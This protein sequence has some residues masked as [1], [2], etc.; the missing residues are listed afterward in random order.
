MKYEENDKHIFSLFWADLDKQKLQVNASLIIDDPQIY[1][2]LTRV[3]RLQ[4]QN[5]C[6]IFGA[7]YHCV[8]ELSSIGAKQVTG[9]IKRC[10][11]TVS[12]KPEITALIPILKKPALEEAVYSAIEL[13]ATEV[14]FVITKKVQR[15]WGGAQERDRLQHI[16][17]AAAEQAKQFMIPSL[18][19]PLM[20]EHTMLEK[21][22]KSHDAGLLFDA[23]GSQI[24]EIAEQTDYHA[25]K[26]NIKKLVLLW[27]PEGGL[28]QEE[29][30]M[31]TRIGFISCA[32]TPTILRAQQ[33]V[34]V[35][36][37]LIRSLLR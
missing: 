3:L 23:F 37:G 18:S 25:I 8:L 7:R 22:I 20:V 4:P 10:S 29:I 36:L 27:G 15:A 19:D 11:L 14:Y 24:S 35:G 2:R 13:G 9:I 33:A 32:L 5:I 6:I 26:Q 1:V 34:A 21:F 28:T 31:A 16:A 12:L 17:I 30:A